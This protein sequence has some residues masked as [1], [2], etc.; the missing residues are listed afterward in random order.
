[1]ITHVTAGMT[2]FRRGD[3]VSI[4]MPYPPMLEELRFLDDNETPR[5]YV[6]DHVIYQHR[7]GLTG[8]LVLIKTCDGGVPVYVLPPNRLNLIERAQCKD[9]IE[10]DELF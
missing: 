4:V 9:L 5:E 2:E 10:M 7:D 8:D 3:I 1:M 6:V